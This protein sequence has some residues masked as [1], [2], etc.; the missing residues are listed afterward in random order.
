MTKQEFFK[1]YTYDLAKDELGDGGFG[2]EYNAFDDGRDR[3]VVV[4]MCSVGK[5]QEN[6]RLLNE[7]EL[8]NRIPDHKNIVHYKAYYRFNMHNCIFECGVLQYY[9]AGNLSQLIKNE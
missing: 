2:V 3:Y 4:K 5:S 8:A 7:I 9:V 6:L 1:R